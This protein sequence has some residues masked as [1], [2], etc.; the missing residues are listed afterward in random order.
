MLTSSANQR[1]S[2]VVLV[3]AVIMTISGVLL[4]GAFA[5]GCLYFWRNRAVADTAAV[6]SARGDDVLRLRAK[7]HPRDDWRFSDENQ[8]SGEEDDLDLA[9]CAAS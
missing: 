7:K 5:F 6:G 1:R 9:R 2:H 4:M 8:M 3:I